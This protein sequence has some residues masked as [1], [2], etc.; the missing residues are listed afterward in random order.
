MEAG[1]VLSRLG[2]IESSLQKRME[3]GP[4]EVEVAQRQVARLLVSVGHMD[5]QVVIEALETLVGAA[6]VCRHE[7]TSYW[8]KALATVRRHKGAEGFSPLVVSRFGSAED[9][10]IA[11]RHL[12]RHRAGLGPMPSRRWRR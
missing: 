9:N 1:A 12:Q 11:A 8:R 10:K 5:H 6:A 4:S 7:E 2:A 3:E